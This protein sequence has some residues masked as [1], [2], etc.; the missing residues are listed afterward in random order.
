MSRFTVP[1]LLFSYLP[2]LGYLF[3][4]HSLLSFFLKFSSL[5]SCSLSSS[6]PSYP[7][8]APFLYCSSAS[9]LFFIFPSLPSHFLFP[10]LSPSF[11]SSHLPSFFLLPF[12]YL[13]FLF[14][15]L[16]PLFLRGSLMKRT[17]SLS[18]PFFPC[19]K[20]MS[21]VFFLPLFAF[22]SCFLSLSSLSFR[23]FVLCIS[24]LIFHALS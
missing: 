11:F 18:L 17:L 3:S 2:S 5:L 13:S 12:S 16:E 15:S 4:L 9:F 10:F 19:S 14:Y 20:F 6:L 23:L 8:F 1:F 22:Y 21:F 24:H 7:F